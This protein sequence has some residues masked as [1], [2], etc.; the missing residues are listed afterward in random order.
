MSILLCVS[1]T[2]VTFGLL[3]VGLDLIFLLI[4]ERAS[5]TSQ[6]MMMAHERVSDQAP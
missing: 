5:N 4:I 2:W 1:I 6:A 3:F